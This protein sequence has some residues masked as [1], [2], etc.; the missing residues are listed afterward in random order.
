M[1]DIEARIE[2]LRPVAGDTIVLSVPG[3]VTAKQRDQ[4]RCA[5]VGLL[6]AAVK[7]LVLDSGITMAH[8][9]APEREPAAPEHPHFDTWYRHRINVAHA[10]FME[11]TSYSVPSDWRTF[12]PE[13]IAAF[14]AGPGV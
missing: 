10:K 5:A 2:V 1:S 7:V 13:A 8:I 9:V 4:I 11:R 14:L 3:R 6:P 12:S